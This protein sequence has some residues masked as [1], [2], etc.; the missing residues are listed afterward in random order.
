M[1]TDPL[2][3]IFAAL[4]DPTRRA[5]I[6]Q[7]THG[8]KTA[9]ELAKPFSMS[10]PAISRHLKVLENANLIDRTVDAQWRRCSL[11]PKGLEEVSN[12][13]SHYQK[14]WADRFAA[15]DDYLEDLKSQGDKTDERDDKGRK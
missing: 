12:W 3:T 11:N 6:D 8:E 15:L 5:I 14:F 4:A 10:A 13:V 1:N 7:L 2:S 9:G